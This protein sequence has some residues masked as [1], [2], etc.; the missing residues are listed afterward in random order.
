M[1]AACLYGDLCP[2]GDSSLYKVKCTYHAN[3]VLY[4][5]VGVLIILLL[6]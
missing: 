6:W 2:Y 3:G 5:T 1:L 4:G